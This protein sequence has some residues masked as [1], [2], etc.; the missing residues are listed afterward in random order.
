M[1]LLVGGACSVEDV[2]TDLRDEL[3]A[4]PYELVSV[5]GGWHHRIRAPLRR[6]IR[7][8][9]TTGASSGLDLSRADLAV[10]AA[11]TYLQP[12]TRRELAGVF[13][14][15]VNHDPSHACAGPI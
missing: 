7:A 9:R 6:P 12:L 10:L 4:R 11:I 15:E 14:V 8:S 1:N 13:G 3:R 5:V 2:I